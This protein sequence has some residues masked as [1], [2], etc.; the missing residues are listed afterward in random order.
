MSAAR[1]R[2]AARPDDEPSAEAP[3]ERADQRGIRRLASVGTKPDPRFTYAN[4]R[5]FLAWIRTSLALVAGGLAA[6]QF[7]SLDPR[8]LRLAV[9]LPL[10]VLGAVTAAMSFPRWMRSERALR[11]GEPLPYSTFLPTL[12]Y[13]VAVTA[14][15]CGIVAAVEFALR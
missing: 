9:A 2:T 13:G 5:T 4:E 12:A 1:S 8:A 10:I 11:L 14:I 15:I 7:L 3:A 6:A